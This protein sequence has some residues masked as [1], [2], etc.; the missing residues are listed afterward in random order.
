[1]RTVIGMGAVLAL[2]LGC[3]SCGIETSEA[4]AQSPA[5]AS[6]CYLLDI[7][8]MTCEQCATHVQKALVGVPGVAEA[9]ITF[10]KAE[11]QACIRPG[12]TVTGET[13]VRAV[14][15]AGYKAKVKWQSQD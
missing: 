9:K 12:Y 3:C 6:R 4:Q 7:K 11:A 13:L 2:S 5:R 10:A 15:K 14:E 1:M 8:G